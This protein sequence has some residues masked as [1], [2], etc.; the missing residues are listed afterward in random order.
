MTHDE[1]CEAP[2]RARKR[3]VTDVAALSHAVHLHSRP[4]IDLQRVAG[5][6]CCS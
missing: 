2:S 4:H 5:A 1:M 3:E 6:L